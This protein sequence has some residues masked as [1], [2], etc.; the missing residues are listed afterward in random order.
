MKRFSDFIKEEVD[1][2]GSK[3]IPSDFMSKA[4]QEARA[5]LGVRLDDESQMRTLWPEFERKMRESNQI[6]TQGLSQAQI[7]E[8]VEKLEKLAEAVVRDRFDEILD[9]AIKP[10]ELKIKLV[11]IGQVSQEIRDIT[12][13]P[14][15]A[16]QPTEKQQEEQD[17]K[18]EENRKKEQ[19]ERS[20]EEQRQHVEEGEETPGTNLVAAVDKKKI[21]NMITQAAG[22]ST[23]DIIRASDIVDEGLQEIFGDSWRRILDCWIR[24]SDIAD[25]M[26]WVIPIDRKSQMLKDMPVGMGGAVQVKWESHSGNFYNMNLLLE[27]EATKIVI[28]ATGVDFPMLIHETIKG[29]YLF[30]Q[31]GAIK[32]DKETAKII[33]AA[34]SSF[35]DEAQDF[36]YGPPAYQ[37][38]L[39]FV[40]MFTESGQYKRLDTR[41]FTMLA[42]D[43]ERAM[44]EAK[45]AKP[46]FKEYLQKKADVARTDEQFLE[47]MKSIFSVF[48]LQ[49]TDYVVNEEKFNTSLAKREIKKIIDYIVEDIESYKSEIEEWE[50]EQR[51][52]EEE[53]KY[54]QEYNDEEGTVEP[55]QEEEESD[56][57][58]LIKQTLY[59]KEEEET[60]SSTE[61]DYS[62][63][64]QRELQELIDDALDAG[65]YKKVQMLA[66][67]MKEGKEVY[68]KEIERINESH[69][70]HTRRK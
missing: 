54:H 42:V 61:V 2:R 9:T 43:K 23:K 41:V 33:K 27:K 18:D 15:Q 29:I 60:S 30:L 17:E 24:I 47:I 36:R 49:G 40:N 14:Q 64:S 21:L 65:D 31:S 69:N 26:D 6:L 3:G 67:Y 5:S 28:H 37:M 34:T 12:S 59:G 38:L 20:E 57:D 58:A 70:F 39:N 56:I 68:L 51:E 13:V 22:K 50:R 53:S 35:V 10:I 63:L 62:E 48:D 4:E 7:K 11:P 32:K 19:E 55:G 45:S 46:E 8:R 16:K 44:I 66:Q 52:R 25:K 1:L